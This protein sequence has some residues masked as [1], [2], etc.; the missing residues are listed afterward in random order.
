[1]TITIVTPKVDKTPI[2]DMLRVIT[3]AICKKTDTRVGGVLGGQFGYGNHWDTNVFMM[4]PYCWCDNEDCLWCSGDN[5]NFLH[6]ASGLK[7]SWYK[8]I[9][10][11]MEIE[12]VPTDLSS[13]LKECLEDIEK[14]KEKV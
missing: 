1:M 11:G 6:K 13:I 5:P 4:H 7:V 9:G 10:R 8:Y 2:C 12:N 3:E 14:H